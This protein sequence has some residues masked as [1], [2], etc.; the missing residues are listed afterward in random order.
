MFCKAVEING[1]LIRDFK[2]INLKLHPLGKKSDDMEDPI[3]KF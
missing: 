2:N 3:R 1:L